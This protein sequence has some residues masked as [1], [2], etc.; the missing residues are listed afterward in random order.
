MIGTSTEWRNPESRA[1]IRPKRTTAIIEETHMTNII[2]E[3][4]E[5]YWTPT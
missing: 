2:P 1:V 3:T 4:I 5:I